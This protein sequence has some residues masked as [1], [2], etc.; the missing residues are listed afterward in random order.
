MDVDNRARSL[1]L[2]NSIPTRCGEHA[3]C[4]LRTPALTRRGGRAFREIF[5][6]LQTNHLTLFLNHLT[7]FLW[8]E[9]T[10]IAY[11]KLEEA[12]QGLL[13][14]SNAQEEDYRKL[15]ETYQGLLAHSNAQQEDY[16]KLEEAYQGLLAHSN[17]LEEEYGRLLSV[18]TKSNKE[19]AAV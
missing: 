9:Q 15:E 5:P 19:H 17:A 1:W 12:Y 4:V 6:D 16:R 8:S 2:G 18:Y 14:H 10:S 7:L 13:A 11:K 3:G